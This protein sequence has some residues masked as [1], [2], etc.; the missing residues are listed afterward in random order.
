MT[1]YVHDTILYDGEVYDIVKVNGEGWVTPALFQMYPK[2]IDMEC[3]REHI[4]TYQVL[5]NY[6]MLEEMVIGEL[7]NK[8]YKRIHG[9]M[10]DENN[11]YSELNFWSRFNGSIRIA[12]K[13]L[14]TSEKKKGPRVD[15]DY[16]IVKD[17]LFQTGEM[18]LD[19]DVSE[20]I[21]QKRNQ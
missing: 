18:L 2:L 4:S 3:K 17:I 11:R 6:I 10:P 8:R 20:E 12:R 14:A 21:A 1:S 7:P 19:K 9:K 5:V 16:E 15:T 13:P